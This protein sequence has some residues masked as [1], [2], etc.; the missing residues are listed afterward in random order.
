MEITAGCFLFFLLSPLLSS[1][2]L[3]KFIGGA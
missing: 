1:F 2:F 3:L